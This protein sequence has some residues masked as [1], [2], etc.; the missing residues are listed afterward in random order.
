MD[1]SNT[2]CNDVG[3]ITRWLYSTL[4][5]VCKYMAGTFWE[6]PVAMSKCLFLGWSRNSSENEELCLPCWIT[7]GWYLRSSSTNIPVAR[8]SIMLHHLSVYFLAANM[9][10]GIIIS[11]WQDRKIWMDNEITSKILSLDDNHWIIGKYGWLSSNDL[12]PVVI[13]PM[14]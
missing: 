6:S 4:A 2:W 11:G 1:R 13:P 5:L 10:V 8:G 3:D 14:I 9:K 12:I 7:K